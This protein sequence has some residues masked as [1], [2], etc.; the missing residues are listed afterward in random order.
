MN[1]RKRASLSELKIEASTQGCDIVLS[2]EE[3]DPVIE[4]LAPNNRIHRVGD[5]IIWNDPLFAESAFSS[6]EAFRV[7]TDLFEEITP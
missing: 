6:P 5:E 1:E 2:K 3:P 7:I 4:A